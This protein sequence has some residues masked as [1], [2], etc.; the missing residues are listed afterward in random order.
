MPFA[1]IISEAQRFDIVCPH[2]D[3]TF[4]CDVWLIVDPGERPDLFKRI[5]TGT[6]HVVVCEK[7]GRTVTVSAPVLIHRSNADPQLLFSPPE[8][9]AAD[10][11]TETLTQLLVHLRDSLGTHWRDEWLEGIVS[12]R[13]AALP[14]ALERSKDALVQVASRDLEPLLIQFIQASLPD[15]NELLLRSPELLGDGSDLA[16]GKLVSL[17]EA[18]EVKDLVMDRHDLLRRCRTA[19]IAEAFAERQ[20]PLST[21]DVGE[22]ELAG[23]WDLYIR[24][25]RIA[26]ERLD[27]AEDPF[28]WA[29]LHGAL[30]NGLFNDPRGD[31]SENLELAIYHHEQAL[32]VYRRGEYPERWALNQSSLAHV[33]V[34]REKGSEEANKKKAIELYH[35]A[36]QEFTETDNP[37]EWAT[38]HLNLGA[39]EPDIEARIAHIK[40]ALRVYTREAYPEKR[41]V[42]LINLAGCY[43][44]GRPG[45]RAEDLELALRTAQ[46]AATIPDQIPANWGHVQSTLARC[47][48][49]RG[50]GD[51]AENLE[52]AIHHG[53]RAV[54]ALPKRD[55]PRQRAFAQ[56][57]LASAYSQRLKGDRAENIETAIRLCT[58]ALTT[59]A[60]EGLSEDSADIQ[61][62]LATLYWERLQGD[63]AENLEQA[64]LCCSQALEI[65]TQDGSP[66]R[67]VELQNNLA[68]FYRDRV[69]GDRSENAELA[70]RCLENCLGYADA[71]HDEH[72][73]AGVHHNLGTSFWNREKGDIEENLARAAHHYREALK[74]RTREEWPAEY[75]QTQRD[76]ANLYFHRSKWR[77]AHSSFGLAIEA[78][79][80]LFESSYTE[81]GRLAAAGDTA[82]LYMHDGYCLLQE[83]RVSEALFRVE[84]GR[85][86]M[87]AEALMAARMSSAAL[88]GAQAAEL[89]Q[90]RDR[91]RLLE[92]RMRRTADEP[93]QHHV[94]DTAE[95]LREAREDLRRIVHTIREHLPDVSPLSLPDLLSLVPERGALVAPVFTTMGTAVFV[96]PSGCSELTASHVVRIEGF[97]SRDLSKILVGDSPGQLDGWLG[98]YD[99]RRKGRRAWRSAIEDMSKMLEQLFA[100][101]VRDTLQ[102]L[103]VVR[104][105]R[106]VYLPQGGLALLPVHA[107][108]LDDYTIVHAPSAAV[109]ASC[110][111]HLETYD[112]TRSLLCV[113]NPTGDLKFAGV[114]SEA[115]AAHFGANNSHCLAGKQATI[116]AVLQA[117]P[118]CSH[119]HFACHGYYAWKDP[120]QSGLV[121]A[122]HE[123][124]TLERI[125]GE[126]NLRGTRLVTLSA[127]ETGVSEFQQAPDEYLSLP[128]AFLQ[129]GVP[130]V[131]ASLWAVD[132]LSTMLLMR[133]F[134]R[135]HLD[136]GLEPAASLR[137][138]QLWLRDATDKELAP[139]LEAQRD[140]SSIVGQRAGEL[141]DTR[142]RTGTS[143]PF[144]HP[145]YWAAF[146]FLGA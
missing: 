25:C 1:H 13:R 112:G 57:E 124:L 100:R 20:A 32:L 23:D 65:Y 29:M 92:S 106:V 79:D 67:W 143:R 58:E 133:E 114:E 84:Q 42:A 52:L 18:P 16:M 33:Y 75:R 96:V 27:R 130:G 146:V 48:M 116:E 87:L 31:R 128:G 59:Y 122:E 7:C 135:R 28:T 64:I 104:G 138:A 82:P 125:L 134:Y 94:R 73:W 53:E 8:G 12:V 80:H 30:G 4:S 37:D 21:Q 140:F 86:R 45:R 93:T 5:Q 43:Q 38:T 77:D 55:F 113:A 131:L 70:L 39:V 66:R 22:A 120:Q 47:F 103:G 97:T 137:A 10:E 3:E 49:A 68:N 19:G 24:R 109:L 9:V 44:K 34:K 26:L 14:G 139:R 89:Q 105:S 56:N 61:S 71:E 115:V 141:L 144:A 108:L 98:A 17:Q 6:L 69:R 51:L 40:R 136:D 15:A 117:R 142:S 88:H 2:C 35:N 46:E 72:F 123:P 102:R 78:G 107:A 76:L 132:D 110:Q 145:F 119:L 90:A 74:L 60:E 127:C 111:R 36:L 11:G 83:G 63:R 126:A 85:T 121:L 41:A 62:S 118:G 129:V 50:S 101:P 95:A 54:A 99:R 81:T 91:V